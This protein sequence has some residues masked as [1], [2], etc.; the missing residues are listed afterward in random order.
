[1]KL[2]NKRSHSFLSWEEFL[3]YK[4]NKTDECYYLLDYRYLQ[5]THTLTLQ[6]ED[7]DQ[8]NIIATS[9]LCKH[10]GIKSNKKN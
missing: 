4:I 8:R 10:D 9:V 1:M 3:P 5:I 2:L 7:E 6:I